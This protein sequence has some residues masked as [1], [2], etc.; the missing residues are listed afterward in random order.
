MKGFIYKITNKVNGKVYIGQTRYTVESRWRQHCKNFNI[1]HR[2]QPL[3]KAFAK[4]GIENFIVETV[5]EVDCTR[6]NEREMFWIAK[7]DSFN[8]GYN[9]TVGGQ[10]GI[11]YWTDSQYEEIRTLYL[12]GFTIKKIAECMNVSHSTIN[13]ILKSLQIKIRRKPMDMNA[14]E[15]N[16][17]IEQYKNGKSLTGIAKDYNTDRETVKRFLLKHNVELKQHNELLNDTQK[18]EQLVNDYLDGTALRELELKY[19]ADSRTIKRILVI[20]GIDINAYRGIKQTRKG[21]F[22]LT[23]KECLEAIRLYTN[24]I[25]SVKD[26]AKKFQINLST[27]YSLLKRYNVSYS[28]YNCSKSVQS[29]PEKSQG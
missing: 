22:C 1:E 23:D 6:L 14:Q 17:V 18:V 25:M 5:E 28:R 27:L 7:Y 4:Y 8:K 16:E 20:Q 26:I 13:S 24:N 11:Y 3:Y 19:H 21:A 9:A 12:S 29:L 2:Q 10:G 15:T